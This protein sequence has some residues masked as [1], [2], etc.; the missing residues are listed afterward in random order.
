MIQLKEKRASIQPIKSKLKIS[1]LEDI[2]IRDINQN[3]RAV[4]ED[5]G[6]R[7]PSEKAL[8]IFAEVGAKVD[9]ETQ[10]VKIP[11]DLLDKYL[12][13]SPRAYNMAGLRPELDVPVG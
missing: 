7:F 2:E 11:A 13:S 12:A 9:W 1:I 3:A 4:L 8:K 6:V 5:V 10:V